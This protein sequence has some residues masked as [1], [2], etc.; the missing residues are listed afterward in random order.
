MCFKQFLWW[1]RECALFIHSCS[2]LTQGCL[3]SRPSMHVDH[4]NVPFIGWQSPQWFSLL[5]G[6]TAFMDIAITSAGHNAATGQGY[7]LSLVLLLSNSAVSC[8]CCNMPFMHPA[9]ICYHHLHWGCSAQE[10]SKNPAQSC[11]GLC[12]KL[13]IPSLHLVF[14]SLVISKKGCLS[15]M[16][17]RV[18]IETAV[19]R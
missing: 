4:V 15:P 8:F 12:G 19:M 14:F 2:S 18:F 3:L 17:Y 10:P 6:A 5:L 7:C 16:L 11:M 9:S 1:P 13:K